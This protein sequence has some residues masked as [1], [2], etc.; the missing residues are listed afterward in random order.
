[1]CNIKRNE[2]IILYCLLLSFFVLSFSGCSFL[3]VASAPFK[4]TKSTVPQTIDKGKKIYKCKGDVTFDG[5]GKVLSCKGGYDSNEEYFIQS[6]RKLTIR[7]KIKAFIDKLTG[8]TLWAFL[9]SIVLTFMGCGVLVSNFWNSVFGVG[10]KALKALLNGIS[11][12]KQY[13]RENGIS[14]TPDELK[15]YNQGCNDVL[16]AIDEATNDPVI[17]KLLY[18]LRGEVKVN[19]KKV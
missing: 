5:N 19:S 4:S 16:D 2:L 7:E 13:V 11:K 9:I 10:N 17:T 14:L 8:W 3:K 6:E 12:G 15:I 1:M 18:K